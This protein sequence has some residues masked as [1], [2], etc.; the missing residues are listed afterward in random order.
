[1][2][3]ARLNASVDPEVL[4][5]FDRTVDNRSQALEDYMRK[6]VDMERSEDEAL[7]E[8]REELSKELEELREK[9]NEIEE[10][11]DTKESELQAIRSTL[12]Q[13][14]EERNALQEALPV[15]RKKY[16]ELHRKRRDAEQ[17][18]HD[19]K[20]TE[21]FHMWLDKVEMES[22]ELQSEIIQELEVNAE[23]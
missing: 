14:N 6:K 1:M 3:K 22:E 19:L 23:L 12:E 21:T 10:K 18:L 2:V 5:R 20:S 16:R 13:R 11:I 15:L 8:R 7:V 17:A 4:R 9:R